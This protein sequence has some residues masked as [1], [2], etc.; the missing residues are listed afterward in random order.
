MLR[1]QQLTLHP[2]D[3][4]RSGPILWKHEILGVEDSSH[5]CVP[6][7]LYLIYFEQQN[8]ENSSFFSL[9]ICYW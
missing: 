7:I 8:T 1:G 4:L 9:T 2:V 6:A 5:S 3:R